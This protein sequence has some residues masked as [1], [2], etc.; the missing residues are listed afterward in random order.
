MQPYAV[1]VF[2]IG[3]HHAQIFGVVTGTADNAQII[4]VPLHAEC[5]LG[6]AA[7]LGNG[8]RD[9][10]QIVAGLQI[11][12]CH[13]DLR[14]HHLA[15][16]KGIDR[17]C[18]CRH[19]LAVL[20]GKRSCR[21]GTVCDRC[22]LCS[23]LHTARDGKRLSGLCG[24]RN[25][26]PQGTDLRPGIGRAGDDM[27]PPHA[28]FVVNGRDQRQP[29]RGISRRRLCGD[30]AG[31]PAETKDH[32]TESRIFGCCDR[33]FYHIVMFVQITHTDL[34]A[35]Q[36]QV[37]LRCHIVHNG[38]RAGHDV[39]IMRFHGRVCILRRVSGI[40]AVCTL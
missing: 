36:L 1:I 8:N 9:R 29:F 7:A 10:D 2:I 40:V 33:N 30:L 18:G 23:V 22:G 6:K 28:V 21:T 34:Y 13:V 15:E 3:L 37:Y 16:G 14:Q 39:D 5:Q 31:V 24:V 26:K 11:L 12:H 32:V 4:G 20:Y 19:D 17:L 38:D 27:N 35:A 25:R